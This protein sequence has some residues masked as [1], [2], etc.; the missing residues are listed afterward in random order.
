MPSPRTPQGGMGE[1][2]HARLLYISPAYNR[3]QFNCRYT[4]LQIL[5]IAVIIE[6]SSEH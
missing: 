6:T 1:L 4:P 3:H 2:P 5:V